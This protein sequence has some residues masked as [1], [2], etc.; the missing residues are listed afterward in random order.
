[1]KRWKVVLIGLIAVALI[2]MPILSNSAIAA[3]KKEEVVEK[4]GEAEG[5]KK[6]SLLWIILGGAAIGGIIAAAAGAAGGGEGAPTHVT[7]GH[8]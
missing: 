4:V 3:P 8:H 2:S 1:M 6:I 7:P 5:K